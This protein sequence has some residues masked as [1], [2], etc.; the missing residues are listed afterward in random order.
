MFDAWEGLAYYGIVQWPT[1]EKPPKKRWYPSR[2]YRTKRDLFYL[3]GMGV[4]FMKRMVVQKLSR[5][6]NSD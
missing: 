4:Y 1:L 2:R 6:N 3:K 5:Y